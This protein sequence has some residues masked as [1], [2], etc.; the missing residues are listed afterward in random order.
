MVQRRVR[1]SPQFI[2]EAQAL[3]PPGGS[4]DGKTSFEEFAAGP[5]RAV[6]T[7]FRRR[8]E[9]QP[10]AIEGT[11]IRYALTHDVPLFPALVVYGVL[12][13]GDI[14]ELVSVII[15]PDYW[16]LVGDDPT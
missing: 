15:D 10:E 7:L 12:V 2:A 9:D 11:G 8:W 4:P 6:E 1:R 3:V 14:I 13:E 5:L 16:D